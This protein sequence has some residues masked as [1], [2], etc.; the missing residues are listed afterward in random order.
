MESPFPG[1]DPYL[2]PHWRSVHHRLITYAGDRLQ[3]ALP[4]RYRVEVEERVFVA[5][6]PDEAR[7]VT[8]DVCV[9]DQGKPP[10]P[11][12]SEAGAGGIASPVV[13]EL[14]EKGLRP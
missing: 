8:A 6:E 11:M 9:V 10:V 4:R 1:M 13:I 12:E 5:G 7:N 3:A 2:E 14:R